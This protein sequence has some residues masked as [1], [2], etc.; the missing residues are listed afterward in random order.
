MSRWVSLLIGGLVL[1]MVLACGFLGS[2]A[3]FHSAIPALSRWEAPYGLEGRESPSERVTMEKVL[4]QQ[5]GGYTLREVV[6]PLPL[7][8]L[9]LA[10]PSRQGKYSD[11][12]QVVHLMAAQM[13]SLEEAHSLVAQVDAEVEMAGARGLERSWRLSASPEGAWKMSRLAF[14][15]HYVRFYIPAWGDQ[16]Y[17]VAWNNGSWLFMAT[18]SSKSAIEDLVSGLDY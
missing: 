11:G 16:A 3:L 4:P 10:G 7:I 9:D 18:S 8:T 5:V 15:K 12:V 17:G 14:D 1:A 6:E 13:K 2:V